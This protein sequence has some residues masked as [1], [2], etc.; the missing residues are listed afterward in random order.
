[1]F[2]MKQTKLAITDEWVTGLVGCG[3]NRGEKAPLFENL[4]LDSL[5]RRRVILRPPLN[6]LEKMP[7][8]SDINL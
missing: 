3:D 5:E 2:I 8:F 6:E 1:M 7:F 4:F